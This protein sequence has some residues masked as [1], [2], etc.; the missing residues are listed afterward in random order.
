MAR[1]LSENAA[2]SVG[3][4]GL[5]EVAAATGEL[6]RTSSLASETVLAQLRSLVVDLLQVAGLGE[7]DAHA[8]IPPERDRD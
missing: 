5:L 3:L 7:E 1:A 2:A 8:A 6:P 4:R